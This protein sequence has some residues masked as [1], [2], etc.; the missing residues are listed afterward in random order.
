[1]IQCL[2]TGQ[3]YVGHTNDLAGRWRDHKVGMVNG[4]PKPLY[5]LMRQQGIENFTY[6]VLES[7]ES[8]YEASTREA[9]EE[10][11]LR[12]SGKCLNVGK[13]AIWDRPTW[14]TTG[15]D[16]QPSKA[17]AVRDRSKPR[18]GHRRPPEE[19]NEYW[20][21]VRAGEIEAPLDWIDGRIVGPGENS[22]GQSE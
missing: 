16:R 7:Y 8:R 13:V 10:V 22:S 21:K 9:K 6:F 19:R 4:S 2:P 20:R 14:D 12:S 11:A 1:M 3:T 17:S 15:K 18:R 5:T